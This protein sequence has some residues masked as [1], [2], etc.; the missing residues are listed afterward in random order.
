[1]SR[2]E[3]LA[4]ARG[5]SAPEQAG[6]LKH[7]LYSERLAY[8]PCEVCNF[9]DLCER[10]APGAHCAFEQIWMEQM[11][12][13]IAQAMQRAG[14]DPDL[15]AAQITAAVHAQIKYQRNWGYRMI[16]G[17]VRVDRE[18]GG[19]VETPSA[20]R[21]ERLRREMHKAYD[22]LGLSAA[23]LAALERGAGGQAIAGMV[24][25]LGQPGALAART[26][27]GSRA[28]EEVA[29]AEVVDAEFEEEPEREQ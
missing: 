24:L 27:E 16:E 28:A 18:A 19:L 25:A 22:E 4:R 12:P 9:G 2:E 14:R 29:E 5:Q 8:L 17:E 20:A 13:K 11:R 6:V 15:Y 23:A 3:S 21:V 10:Y 1:M 7:A 26:D